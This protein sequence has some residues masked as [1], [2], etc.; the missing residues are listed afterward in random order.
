MSE[1]RGEERFLVRCRSP[2]RIPLL[3]S[4]GLRRE[5][6]GGREGRG[7]TATVVVD[8]RAAME[9]WGKKGNSL[10]RD[11][12]GRGGGE[13]STYILY[14]RVQER[15]GL[16]SGEMLLLLPPP[17]SLLLA[18]SDGWKM[19]GGREEGS[20][21]Q[22]N[23]TEEAEREREEAKLP[24]K[25]TG[26]HEQEEEVLESD[27]KRGRIVD[28][29]SPPPPCS[30]L[31]LTG[32]PS[33]LHSFR[34]VCLLLLF[35]FF[36]Y[37]FLFPLL[38]L[39]HCGD[40]SSLLLTRWAPFLL[41]HSHT[42]ARRIPHFFSNS[43]SPPPTFLA[44]STYS[45]RYSRTSGFTCLCMGDCWKNRRRIARN[46]ED[47]EEGGSF[48]NQPRERHSAEMFF[49]MLGRSPFFPLSLEAGRA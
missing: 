7:R 1:R 35:F 17:A 10:G 25:E 29:S 13:K 26:R 45:T 12:L 11:F 8:R 19:W 20:R 6:K 5:W 23:S 43:S 39:L 32:L 24:R 49:L 41:A 16:L 28:G 48:S 38:F 4:Q 36:F 21:S 33:S 40:H 27:S 47:S 22:S 9:R 46:H 42:Q 30:R 14:V 2:L 34:P 15:W 3:A 37:S 44:I 31:T 18:I